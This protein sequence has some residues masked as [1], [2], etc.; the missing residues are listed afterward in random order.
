MS[1]DE[2]ARATR[3]YEVEEYGGPDAWA[4][5]DRFAVFKCEAPGYTIAEWR[6][7]GF[8][9]EHVTE[10]E[11]QAACDRLNLAAVLE[12]LREPSMRMITVGWQRPS[13]APAEQWRTMID[14]LLAEV[15][16]TTG[17]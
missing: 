8:V 3:R 5:L 7:N 2:A 10:D 15:K 12:A 17:A 4:D 11:A 14:A 16:E 6:A 9:S 13:M 1:I